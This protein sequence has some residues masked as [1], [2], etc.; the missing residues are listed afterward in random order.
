[1]SLAHSR[2]LAE[3]VNRIRQ[4]ADE[5][6]TDLL[7]V[8]A[9]QLQ[10]PAKEGEGPTLGRKVRRAALDQLGRA[11]ALGESPDS[12][13]GVLRLIDLISP[14]PAQIREWASMV[15]SSQEPAVILEFLELHRHDRARA[16]FLR[17]LMHEVV[18]RGFDGRDDPTMNDLAEAMRAEQHPLAA[19]PLALIE[20]ES[21]FAEL[22][23]QYTLQSTSAWLDFGLAE[24]LRASS[25]AAD[26]ATR[27]IVDTTTPAVQTALKAAVMGWE[28]DS[29]G[30][31]E[32]RTFQ[33]D[34]GLTA[35][36]LSPTLLK[37][38]RLDCLPHDHTGVLNGSAI[39]PARALG[40]LFS[41]AA[42]GGAYNSGERG[43]YGR[44]AAWKSASALTSKEP[45]DDI[46]TIAQAVLRCDWLTFHAPGK[47]FSD[48]AWDFGLLALRPSGTTLAV[49]AATDTD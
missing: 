43:A 35:K 33:I 49:L 17:L 44:L 9:A 39:T 23:P 34:P 20:I 10:N 48:V 19:L 29:N 7:L 2:D 31:V 11:L 21:G 22:L 28:T 5:G 15:A 8:E 24:P 25:E 42:D 46:P 13:E 6:R 32:A 18:L 14:A 40:I 1:M 38:L 47:W 16:E 4:W 3:L 36:D 45:I 12:V 26:T 37:S 27:T 41:V 30:V